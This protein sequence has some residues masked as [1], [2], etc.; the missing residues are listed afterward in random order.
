MTRL[1]AALHA[2]LGHIR[3]AAIQIVHHARMARSPS[4]VRHSARHVTQAAQ[5]ALKLRQRAGSALPDTGC[6]A[7]NVHCVCPTSS[8]QVVYPSVWAVQMER[9]L[10]MEHQNART[11][12]RVAQSAMMKFH[13]ACVH[14]ASNRMVP[15]VLDV[16]PGT[17]QQVATAPVSNALLGHLQQR[18]PLAALP[19]TVE[20]GQIQG[21][22]RVPPVQIAVR[23]AMEPQCVRSAR[24]GILCRRAS[25]SFQLIFT[26]LMVGQRTMVA[27]QVRPIRV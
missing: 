10:V 4:M 16:L 17:R 26:S 25:V 14:P 23:G 20:N 9:I 6:M 27:V 21:P 8:R 1:P 22:D 13:A 3:T 11:V 5:H 18:M 15:V 2:K 19:A 12:R 24:T 7:L